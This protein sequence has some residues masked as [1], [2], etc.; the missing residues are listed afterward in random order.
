M[1][2]TVYHHH[3]K[4]ICSTYKSQLKGK[5]NKKPSV[6]KIIPIYSKPSPQ[7]PSLPKQERKNRKDKKEEKEKTR[8]ERKKKKERQIKNTDKN[9]IT[10]FLLWV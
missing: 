5:N 1:G 8:Q 6:E 4:T 7:K 2:S 3:L 10:P 9:L